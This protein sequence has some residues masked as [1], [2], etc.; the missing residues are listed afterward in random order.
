[1]QTT[2]ISGTAVFTELAAEWDALAAQGMTDTPFQTLA[3]QQTWWQ[4]LRP[5]NANLQTITVRQPDGELTAI[6]CLYVTAEGIVYFNGCVE[7]TDYLDLICTPENAAAAWTAVFDRL[8]SPQFPKWTTLELCNIPAAS[9]SRTVLPQLAQNQ[10]LKA[11][12]TISEVCPIIQLPDTFEAYLDNLDSKQRREI[13]RKLRRAAGANVTIHIVGPEDDLASEV[14]AFLELLQKST[15]EKR[16]WLTD[17]RRAVFH[18]TAQSALANGTLQLM[19]AE[20]NGQKAAAL[21]NFDYQDRIW[22]YN[23]GLDPSAF[24]ALSLGVVLT[25]KA[26]EQAIEN[27]RSQFDF[28]RGSE[29]YKYRFGAKDTE[30]FKITISREA[31]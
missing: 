31:S 6:A 15:F 4:N 23:S 29:T 16:E 28:L 10:G 9:A 8:G 26:I 21:F 19:F 3:Y 25:A 17:S 27:G 11:T 20:V 14:T 24:G 30:I 22:V 13:N 1:M 2:L 5:S 7:E 12:E 18:E